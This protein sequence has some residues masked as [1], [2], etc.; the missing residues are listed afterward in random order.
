MKTL[1]IALGLVLLS[2]TNALAIDLQNKDSQ[3]YL[4]KITE[5]G[6]SREISIEAGQ[7]LT[8]VC[9]S[10][11]QV[12]IEGIGSVNGI[13]SEK[14]SIENGNFVFDTDVQV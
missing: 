3:G 14:I 5:G 7:T 2:T 4:V 9:S 8:K 12:D 1:L 11:C 13:G 10:S 6:R